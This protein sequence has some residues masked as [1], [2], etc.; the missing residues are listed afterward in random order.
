MRSYSFLLLSQQVSFLGFRCKDSNYF[1]KNKKR[2]SLFI[3]T[4]A[5][6]SVFYYFE[7]VGS[8]NAV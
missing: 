6:F 4:R 8:R 1:V 5:L 2:Y 7:A 3:Y